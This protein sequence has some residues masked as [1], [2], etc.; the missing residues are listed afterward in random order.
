ML[1]RDKK[2]RKRKKIL[3]DTSLCCSD[4]VNYDVSYFRLV[5][6]RKQIRQTAS[7]CAEQ[8]DDQA[9][10]TAELHWPW[11]DGV[12]AGNDSLARGLSN[13]TPSVK[14]SRDALSTTHS[15]PVQAASVADV[16]TLQWSTSLG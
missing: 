11:S 10:E 2:Y 8:I 4:K 6:K 14:V 7:I 9:A 12:M 15:N 3:L 16:D 1:S 5:E 13:T